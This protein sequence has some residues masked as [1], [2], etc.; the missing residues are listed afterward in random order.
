MLKRASIGPPAK[1]LLAAIIL[2]AAGL[3][4][5]GNGRVSLWDRDEPRYAQ[6]SRQMLEGF[7]GPRG[8]HG[9]DLA[10]P[11]FLDDLRTEKPPLIYWCQAAAMKV[12]GQNAFAARLPSAV[13]MTLV[14]TLLA[15]V[16]Y[17][18]VGPVRATW[19]VFILATSAL[20]IMSAKMCLTDAVLLLWITIALA[21]VYAVYRGNRSWLVTIILWAALGLGGLTKGPIVLAVVAVTLAALLILDFFPGRRLHIGWWLGLRPWVGAVI[22][23]AIAGPWLWV[24]N[25]RAPTFL[26][27]IFAT[28]ERH[29]A[30]GALKHTGPPGYYLA[31]IWGLFFPWCLLLP[32]TLVIAWRNRHLPIIRF[33][34]AI[35]IGVWVFQEL[36]KTK[37][38]FYLLPAFPALALLTA[39]ALVRCL[40][41]AYD[42][43]LRPSFVVAVAIWAVA[44]VAMGTAPWL[45]LRAKLG[46]ADLVPKPA[47][48]AITL[49]AVAYAAIVLGLF[50]A[51]RLVPGAIAMGI[52]MAVLFA[53][54]FDAYLPNAQYLRTSDRVAAVLSRQGLRPGDAIMIEYK[55][56]SLAFD[57]HGLILEESKGRFLDETP[58]QQWP[59]YVVMPVTVW[60]RTRPQSKALL[61]VIAGPIRGINYAGKIDGRQIVDVMVL[62][63][64]E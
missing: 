29:L 32:T 3:Y 28:A 60:E 64:K 12:L 49:V 26:H 25:H 9:P 61:E 56:P 6:C 36:M 11:H 43:L 42:D 27:R 5:L 44:V 39:D 18:A 22:L 24:V 7:P 34:L 20:T 14:L 31:T 21:C 55:E 48:A 57:L 2:G 40:R 15:V 63:T 46:I 19:T 53:I 59:R 10:V 4:L 54:L 38:P 41:R 50:K 58:P 23:A 52:G 13:G 37:L 30:A 35:V 16:L 33:C 62:R 47:T 45:L 51:R 1:L 17:R 8:A